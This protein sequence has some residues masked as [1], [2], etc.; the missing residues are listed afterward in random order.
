MIDISAQLYW[1]SFIIQ[2]SYRPD[3]NTTPPPPPP[4]HV[5]KHIWPCHDLD[6]WPTD[7]TLVR[8]TSSLYGWHFCTVYWNSF[9]IQQSYRP[10]T[11]TTPYSM[12]FNTADLV[13]T[14]DLWPTD[15]TLARDTSSLHGWHLC[16]VILKFIHNS[17]K[18]T[19]RTRTLP[20]IFHVFKHIWPC[21]DLDLWPTD[22][23]LARDTSSLYG[24]HF[25]TAILKLIHNSK[26]LQTGHEHYWNSFIIQ[27][28]YRP[29]TNTTPHIPCF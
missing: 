15:M 3:T 25:W 28:S 22:M 6:L 10:D 29:D 2:K 13:M 7:M 8:D 4:F 27:K 23:T 14:F 20:P 16:I 26:K 21:R 12:F 24:W 11:N 9:I 17:K 1:N 19:D 18:V 5:F